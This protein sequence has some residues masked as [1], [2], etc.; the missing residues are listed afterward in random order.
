LALYSASYC[1]SWKLYM[2][3]FYSSILILTIK[4][5]PSIFRI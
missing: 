5:N 1:E 4:T 2:C 3:V